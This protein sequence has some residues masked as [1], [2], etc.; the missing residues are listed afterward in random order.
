MK[1]TFHKITAVMVLACIVATMFA[2][3]AVAASKH[4]ISGT[5]RSDGGWYVSGID[6]MVP[7]ANTSIRASFY[8][9]C[10]RSMYFKLLNA[11]TGAQFGSTIVA[12]GDVQ[13]L[14]TGVKAGTLFNNAF[15]L[16][17]S[18]YFW[19]DRTFAGYQWY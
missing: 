12:S 18:C 16:S 11:N 4:S 2:L 13:T 14:A 9:L 8:D 7:S 15:K 1:V 10:V 5:C 3:P 17:S 6:R 19:Q